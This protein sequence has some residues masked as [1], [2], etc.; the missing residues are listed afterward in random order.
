MQVKCLF[1]KMP[2]RP[3]KAQ[4]AFTWRQASLPASECGFQPRVPAPQMQVRIRQRRGG[5]VCFDDMTLTPVRDIFNPKNKVV[6]T[7]HI[8]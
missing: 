5:L 8:K 3:K 7:K 4:N 6:T 2:G 1:E